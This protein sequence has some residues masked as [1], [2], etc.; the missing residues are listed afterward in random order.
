ME[1]CAQAMEHATDVLVLNLVVGVV[2]FCEV[3]E[4]TRADPQCEGEYFD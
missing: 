2:A 4:G 3:D 1:P